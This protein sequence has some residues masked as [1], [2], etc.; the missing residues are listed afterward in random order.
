M[1]FESWLIFV[2]RFFVLIVVL[3]VLYLVFFLFIFGIIFFR[4]LVNVWIFGYLKVE[5]EDKVIFKLIWII[6]LKFN[7]ISEFIFKL[8]NFFFGFGKL[9][10]FCFNILVIILIK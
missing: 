7:V 9:F 6:C 4:Y 3:F 5:V 1:F 2:I 10:L 8:K